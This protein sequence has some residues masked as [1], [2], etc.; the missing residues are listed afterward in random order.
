[1]STAALDELYRAAI[2]DH[3][4]SPR[5]M[6][7][8]ADA[9]HE[10][11]DANR[12][13]GDAV[14]IRLRV[15]GGRIDEARFEGEGCAISQASASMLA[16][17]LCGKRIDDAALLASDLRS[18][19]EAAGV[20]APGLAGLLAGVRAFPERISCALLSIHALERALS[21]A[22]TREAV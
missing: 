17:A 4:R 9:T 6:G 19:L 12:L 11:S 21:G 18:A 3:G 15:A 1:M 10:G 22:K 20:P 13:C 2:L 8:L 5:C 7:K 14:T 16:E